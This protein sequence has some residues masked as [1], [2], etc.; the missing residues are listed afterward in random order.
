MN[1]FIDSQGV[2]IPIMHAPVYDQMQQTILSGLGLVW[3]GEDTSQQA[4]D[5]LTPKVDALLQGKS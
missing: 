1:V 3:T 4:G 5:E 2:S